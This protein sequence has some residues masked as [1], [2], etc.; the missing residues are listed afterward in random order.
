MNYFDLY[1]I[2]LVVNHDINTVSRMCFAIDLNVW[3]S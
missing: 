1:I 2:L 3:Q